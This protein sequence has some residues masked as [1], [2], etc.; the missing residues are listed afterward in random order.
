M[1]SLFSKTQ[2]IAALILVTVYAP[3][4]FEKQ[5]SAIGNACWFIGA[6]VGAFL[7][8]WLFRA[9]WYTAAKVAA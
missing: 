5:P 9:V 4:I 7:M 1:K 6:Y 3:F 8:V 2:A